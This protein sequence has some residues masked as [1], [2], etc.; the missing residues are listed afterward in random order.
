MDHD[1]DEETIEL[2]ISGNASDEQCAQV[3]E[4]LTWSSRV[5]ERLARGGML[6]QIDADLH[7][8]A[9]L[10]SQAVYAL[11]EVRERGTDPSILGR[12]DAWLTRL[13]SAI[14]SFAII[15][16]P[17]PARG[18]ESA[19]P[20]TVPFIEIESGSDH[21]FELAQ[22]LEGL[23]IVVTTT[24]HVF[25]VIFATTEGYRPL[26]AECR[27]DSGEFARASF[28]GLKRGRYVVLAE[29]V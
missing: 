2:Y 3:E 6:D 16:V 15:F 25:V 7:Y 5:R 11:K 4:A 21:Q 20:A 28:S 9:F 29:K 14:G 19:P 10:Q 18:S 24:E 13:S 23:D 1:I 17:A 26:L 8:H 27:V 12:L 22:D